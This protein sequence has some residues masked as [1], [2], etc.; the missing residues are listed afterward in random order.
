MGEFYLSKVYF[1]K[2][3]FYKTNKQTKTHTNNGKCG[4]LNQHNLC[5]KV[6]SIVCYLSE[7][8]KKNI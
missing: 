3:D 6:T 8:F 2:V 5:T 4:V 7:N 1:N